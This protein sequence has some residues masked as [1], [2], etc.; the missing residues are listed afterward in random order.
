MAEEIKALTFEIVDGKF[1][2]KVDPNKDGEN[3]VEIKI[4]MLEV[5]DEVLSLF[6][7]D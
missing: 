5:P 3:V 2:I 1:L 6:K 7:K 4:D